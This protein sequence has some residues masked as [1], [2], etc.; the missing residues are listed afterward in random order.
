MSSSE[1]QA[2]GPSHPGGEGGVTPITRD[3][4]EAYLNC[5]YKGY[6]KLTGQ[7]GRPSDYDVL[8]KEVRQEL[9]QRASESLVR[10]NRDEE[11][12]R[13][14]VITPSTLATRPPL[15]LDAVIEDGGF[16][17]IIDALKRVDASSGQPNSQY[18]PI[19]IFEGE[20]VRKEHR[21]VLEVYALALGRVQGAEP[22][23]GVIVHGRGCRSTRG[24]FKGGL[25][26]AARTL[27]ELSRLA[28]PDPPPLVLN[29][30]CQVCEFRR[31]CLEEARA[32]DDISLLRGLNERAKRKLKKKG[33][34]TV[35]QLSYTF[36]PRKETKREVKNRR[37]HSYGLQALAIRDGKTYV[38][39][40]PELPSGR[41][42][43][44]LDVE[45]DPERNLVYLIG[46]II[47]RGGEEERF[48]LIHETTASGRATRRASSDPACP[49]PCEVGRLS[50]SESGVRATKGRRW[51]SLSSGAGPAAPVTPTPPA[52]A[53]S[54]RR[55]P[56]GGLPDTSAS[57]RGASFWADDEA[58]AERIFRQF[59]DV[60]GRYGD[61]TLF[62][63]GRYEADYLKRMRAKSGSKRLIDRLLEGSVNVLRA[64]YGKVYFPVY[65]N[66]LKDI[67]A[68]VGFSWTEEDAS[69]VMSLVWRRRWERGDGEEFKD[70]LLRYNLEDC[71]ALKRVTEVVGGIVAAY[72]EPNQGIGDGSAAGVPWA[73]AS[74]AVPDYRRWSH[75]HF[76]CPDYD[77]INKCSYFDYQRQRVYIRTSRT[78]RQVEKQRDRAERRKLRISRTVELR[79]RTCPVC[80]GPVVRKE[81]LPYRKVVY[82]L[83]ISHFGARRKVIECC[84][85]LHRCP[86][87]GLTFL[88]R[89][90]KKLDRFGH[91][92]KS[93]AMYLHVAHQ[94]SFPKLETLFRDLFGLKV[95]A[96]RIQWMKRVMA[97]YHSPTVKRIIQQLVAGEVIYADETEVK[98]KKT[99]GY[100]WVLSNTVEVLYVYRPTREVDFLAGLLS[101]FTGV[102]VTDFYPAYDSLDYAQQ[103][104]LVHLIRDLNA[105]L[106]A[107]PF[108]EDFK[109]FAFEFGKLLRAIV[110]TIDEHGLKRRYLAKHRKDVDRFYE[111][112]VR[113]PSDSE[114]LVRFQERFLK[115][116]SQLFQFLDHD[117]VTWN[118]N[119][120]EHAVKQFAH[121]RVI[122][123]GNMNESG[124]HSYLVLLS[125]SQTCK[126]QGVAL[127]DFLLSGERDIDRFRSGGRRRRQM[128]SIAALP[129][130][131]YIPWPGPLYE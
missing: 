80:C 65:S 107:S 89:K 46:M 100:V 105:S 63:Y 47:D 79:A 97:S 108:D 106:L 60:V 112:E 85:Y 74:Q 59:L 129:K 18:V 90:F 114:A 8:M 27:E 126:N 117:G 68:A 124:L 7:T 91:G 62:F 118:N 122:S 115:Y 119:F 103:K 98:L 70:K 128:P 4:L 20:K 88:P 39:G 13:G 120:A 54:R 26:R 104:C 56:R 64:I 2:Q 30:H 42:R 67:A 75:V 73:K 16:S 58:G 41:V 17:L 9:R 31:R 37:P 24:H 6:L 51:W 78:L 5:K 57:G 50:R 111:E 121:Y 11:I 125:V 81:R 66:G 101:G 12:L 76:A 99:K 34:T 93:W 33:I 21:Q 23:S 43:I 55:P 29:D 131:F 71:A 1:H 102:L 83:K 48:S 96:P 116:E 32:K 92:L 38:Y 22:K 36:R 77:F 82:D 72:G 40:T 84:A 10:R 87:C 95:D 113:R 14:P 15:I 3:I 52:G 123:D 130:R 19:L 69:G 109:R 94:I 45:G 86:A 35:T 127:L 61:C 44:Y 53:T 110:T 28:G 49:L 25:S